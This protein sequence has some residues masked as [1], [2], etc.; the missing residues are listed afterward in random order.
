MYIKGIFFLLA[1]K[2]YNRLGFS[3]LQ[4]A[5]SALMYVHQFINDFD[6]RLSIYVQP[7]G[8]KKANDCSFLVIK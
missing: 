1:L 4:F 5:I 6:E 2:Q 8:C 3:E 7:L